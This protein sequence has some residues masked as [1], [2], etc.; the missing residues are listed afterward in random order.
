MRLP[1]A[2]AVHSWRQVSVSLIDHWGKV[3]LIS[4]TIASCCRGIHSCH[5]A[6]VL[7]VV[8]RATWCIYRQMIVIDADTVSLGIL[9]GEQTCLQHL[10]RRSADTGYQ[11]AWG[12]RSLLGFREVVFNITIQC[13]ASYVL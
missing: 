13:Q 1:A 6:I 11:V 5:C 4:M 10:V 8:H 12:K 9:V 7:V 2:V 3:H